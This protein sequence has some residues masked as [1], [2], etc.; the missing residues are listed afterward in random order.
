M[1]FCKDDIIKIEFINNTLERNK[2]KAFENHIKR[3][4]LCQ[5]EIDELRILLP[6]LFS[7]RGPL[8]PNSLVKSTMDRLNKE[9]MGEI[10]IPEKKTRPITKKWGFLSY[11][12]T[13]ILVIGAYVLLTFILNL[14]GV[15]EYLSS[16]FGSL[17]VKLKG[18]LGIQ[19]HGEVVF[20]KSIILFVSLLSL[21]FI[22]FIIEN[23]Y[24]LL[25]KKN[26]FNGG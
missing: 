6:H 10:T 21:L 4:S 26:G 19:Q 20:L 16:Q 17:S 7:M 24:L 23:I 14:S 15:Q 9:V 12:I 1:N 2:K 13:T 11:S 8:V 25:K 3:C 22:P 18:L 5:Q